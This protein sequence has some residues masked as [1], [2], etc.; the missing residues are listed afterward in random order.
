M[1][2][3]SVDVKMPFEIRDGVRLIDLAAF[4]GAAGAGRWQMCAVC[5]EARAQETIQLPKLK[6]RA[7]KVITAVFCQSTIEGA[8]RDKD[9]LSVRC[10]LKLFGSTTDT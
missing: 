5:Q 9:I 10:G 1:T 7:A 6:L 3:I 8:A 2:L 4:G